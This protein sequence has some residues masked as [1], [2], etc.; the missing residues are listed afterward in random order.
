MARG[1][2][3]VEIMAKDNMAPITSA[4]ATGTLT[5]IVAGRPRVTRLAV[6]QGGMIYVYDPPT[7]HIVTQSAIG[8]T[9]GVRRIVAQLTVCG[10]AVIHP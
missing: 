1:A 7:L 8:D 5:L 2:V 10:A 3:A 4:M 6:D 9:V